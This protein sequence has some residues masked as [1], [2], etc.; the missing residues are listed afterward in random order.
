[1]QKNKTEGRFI[2]IEGLDG[3]GQSTMAKLLAEYLE[4]KDIE[5]LLTK[6]PTPDSESGKRIRAV[7]DKKAK[8]SAE[9]LQKFFA[10]DRFE[11]LE[12]AV[13]PALNEGKF[14]VS[15]R[16]FFTSFAYGSA[17][18]IDLDWLIRL[19]DGYLYPDLTFFLKASTETCMKRLEARDGGKKDYFE[20]PEKLAKAWE[21]F[22][23]LPDRFEDIVMIDGERPIAEVFDTIKHEVE[24]RILDKMAKMPKLV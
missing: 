24:R 9:D 13:V 14:V 15:D 7:L 3:S 17:E 8:V 12:N 19:N 18:G 16:Y 4:S 23:I 21:T 10:T 2:V 22:Q 1:M 5:V 6:E 20:T 11:H